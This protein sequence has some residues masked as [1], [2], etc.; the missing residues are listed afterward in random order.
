[1]KMLEVALTSSA[2]KNPFLP[3]PTKSKK[4]LI[5]RQLGLDAFS[6]SLLIHGAF[7][8]VAVVFFYQWIYPPA[9]ELIFVAP[10]GGQG[11]NAQTKAQTQRQQVVMPIN[12]AKI[13]AAVVSDVV[14]PNALSV[15][16]D[17]LLPT[18]MSGVVGGIGEKQGIGGGFG[19]GP[20]IGVGVGPGIGQGF[21]SPFGGS[22]EV[23]SA[24]QGRFYD[25]KQDRNGKPTAG[26]SISNKEDFVSRILKIQDGG[27]RESTIRKFFQAPDALYLTQLAIPS[28]NADLAPKFFNVADKVQ[29]SGWLIVYDGKIASA[30]D[31][32]FRFVG[33]GDDY[34]SVFSNRRAKLINGWPDMRADV[35]ERWESSEAI[36]TNAPSPLPGS[37]LVKGDWITLRKGEPMDLSVAVGERPGGL[38]GFVLLIEEKAAAY[39]TAKNGA[40]VLP[41][42]TT[43]PISNEARERISGDFP[44]WEFEWDNVPVFGVDKASRLSKD[45]R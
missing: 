19:N 7:L 6:I 39:R 20:E 41:L 38:V 15:M 14:M 9:E 24:M 37:H 10:G 34:I 3:E 8:T 42:F 2:M 45:L 35:S 17:S 18:K 25:F 4:P 5:T 21:M 1:M 33:T 26:Y 44:E 32:T 12:A 27:F 11:A 31:I 23:N 43:Q 30:R 13:S 16:T 28:S 40:Q 29:P 36:N 22:L